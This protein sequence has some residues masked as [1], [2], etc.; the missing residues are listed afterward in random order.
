[1]D[2]PSV[3]WMEENLG[4]KKAV[5]NDGFVAV[6]DYMGDDTAIAEAARISYGRAAGVDQEADRKL[7]NYMMAHH[8]TSPFEQCEIKLHVRVPMDCW[9]QWIRHR[10]ANVN[11]YS[12]RFTT[13][14]DS[15]QK[16]KNNQW[17][18]QN[19][20]N[21]QGS[22][23]KVQINIGQ[24]LTSQE[25]QFHKTAKELYQVRLANGVAR[26]QARKD[27]P[28][29]TYT[30]AIWKIDLHNLL[31]FL[32]LRLD[33]HAQYEIMMY[34]RAI[35]DIV[36]DW[37]PQTWSSFCNYRLGSTSLS[38]A[39]SEVIRAINVSDFNAH[40]IS[41]AKDFGFLYK[42][43]FEWLVS[44]NGAELEDKLKYLNIR[45]PWIGIND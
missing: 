6:I 13:A 25:N 28:L 9:R 44:R 8:H 45:I 15:A 11:E 34:A 1:M 20:G 33:E 35:A 27:L 30:E 39:E 16:T 40:A 14:I 10:T 7:I 4:I 42:K 41:I 5:L 12:T 2:R 21:K 19:P 18:L 43:G 23:G 29:S 31:H 17:R 36:A 22:V 24:M 32:Q 3:P 38:D 37:V 26:E